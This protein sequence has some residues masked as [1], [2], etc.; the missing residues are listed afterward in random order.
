MPRENQNGHSVRLIKA[1]VTHDRWTRKELATACG[2]SRD[3]IERLVTALH[4]AKVIHIDEWLD[5]TRG[6][7]SI[8]VFTL[9]P[10]QDA[11]KRTALTG[12]AR[13]AAYKARQKQHAQVVLQQAL[14][15][16]AQQK[17][18]A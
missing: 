12:R 5:D 15:S 2:W 14:A 4:Q 8:A 17:E 18:P 16:W 13:T 9:G 11:R 1:L 6:R 7:Q 10:G 3:R